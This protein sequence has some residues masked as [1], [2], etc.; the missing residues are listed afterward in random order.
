M[1]PPHTRPSVVCPVSLRNLNATLP[2]G[3][4]VSSCV[5]IKDTNEKGKKKQRSQY[6]FVTVSD[7]SHSE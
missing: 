1:S 6:V 4:P 5:L 2:P 3:P 7:V